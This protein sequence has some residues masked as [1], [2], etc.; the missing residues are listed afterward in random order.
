MFLL[1][2]LLCGDG[3]EIRCE[4]DAPGWTG[5][6]EDGE[7]VFNYVGLCPGCAK[8]ANVPPTCR[9]NRS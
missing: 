2:C 6:E 3:V 9:D 8:R 4:E 5:I 7:A 1:N